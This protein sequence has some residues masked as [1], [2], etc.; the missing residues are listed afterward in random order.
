MLFSQVKS[1]RMSLKLRSAYFVSSSEHSFLTYASSFR[2]VKMNVDSGR[3]SRRWIASALPRPRLVPVT[4]MV[5][6]FAG[7]ILDIF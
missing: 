4:K 3:F 7:Y 5:S 2:E 6:L 1:S